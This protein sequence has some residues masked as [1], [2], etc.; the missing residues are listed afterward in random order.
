MRVLTVTRS[1]RP[2][3]ILRARDEAQAVRRACAMAQLPVDAGGR[4]EPLAARE[5]TDA[6]MIGWLIRR[7]DHLLA[8]IDG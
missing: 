6:E 3:A 2:F 8:P 1:S 4:G 7:D 5:P